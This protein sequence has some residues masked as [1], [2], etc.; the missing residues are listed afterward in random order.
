[1]VPLLGL[2]PDGVYLAGP[3]TRT[4]G[5][6]L[7]HPFTTARNGTFSA[8]NPRG[9]RLSTVSSARRGSKP[10]LQCC[11]RRHACALEPFGSPRARTE[12]HRRFRL[13]CPTVSFLWHFPA[14]HLD[15]TLSGILSFGARTFLPSFWDRRSPGVL[16]RRP[17]LFQVVLF[18]E[19]TSV[20]RAYAR[21]N[22][23]FRAVYPAKAGACSAGKYEK[24]CPA[25][26]SQCAEPGQ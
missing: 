11:T 10:F 14:S 13:Q 9:I 25:G 15:R 21:A 19:R 4:A 16:Q 3:V 12:V 2:A 5:E 26:C 8:S 1:M 18:W 6:L 17:T 20:P 7:P 23:H 24:T 22:H